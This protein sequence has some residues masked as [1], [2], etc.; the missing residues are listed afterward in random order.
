VAAYARYQGQHRIHIQ[1][2]G[3]T[4]SGIKEVFAAAFVRN[5]GVNK[6]TESEIQRLYCEI[7]KSWSG[8]Q[9]RD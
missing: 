9:V 8:L 7:W 2:P 3:R 1:S 5:E 6:R 4:S